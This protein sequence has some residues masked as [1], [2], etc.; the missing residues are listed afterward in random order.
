VSFFSEPGFF[1]YQAKAVFG[2]RSGVEQCSAL[3]SDR[4]DDLFSDVGN[5]DVGN[6]DFDPDDDGEKQ[7][8]GE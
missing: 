8:A 3:E 1:R 5:S 7:L 4:V 6:S 2:G